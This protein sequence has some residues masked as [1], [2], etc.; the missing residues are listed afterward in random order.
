MPR[1]E[2]REPG[3]QEKSERRQE[4]LGQRQEKMAQRQE[5]RERKRVPLSEMTP[6]RLARAMW[7]ETILRDKPD[8]DQAK[9][10]ELWRADK[11]HYVELCRAIMQRLRKRAEGEDSEA[12][13]E[14]PPA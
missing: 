7:A 12:D 3:N 14:P 4:K 8:L 13:N 11:E 10:K 1:Q 9:R 6:G 2:G 5:K